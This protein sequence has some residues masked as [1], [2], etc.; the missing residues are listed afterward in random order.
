MKIALASVIKASASAAPAR[1]RIRNA[2][3]VFR[4]LSLNAAKN[5][6]QNSGAKRLESTRE[7]GIPLIIAE[8]QQTRVTLHTKKWGGLLAAHS[9]RYRLRRVLTMTNG[10]G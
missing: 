9:G 7:S 5:W 4:K 3:A 6:H 8:L 10:L 2:S 1:N